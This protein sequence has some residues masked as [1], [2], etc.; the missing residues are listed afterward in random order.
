LSRQES[1]HPEDWLTKARQDMARV[2]VLLD[3]D[4]PEGAGFHLQQAVEKA[5]KAFLLSQG[6]MPR[7]IHDLGILLDEVGSFRPDL[8][9]FRGLCDLATDLY[10]PQRYPFLAVQPPA[11]AEVEALLAQAQALLQKI[12]EV[13]AP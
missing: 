2:R 8:E 6:V 13:F 5:L 7:R 10:M 4:D 12:E 11:K 9:Q 1:R 3:V